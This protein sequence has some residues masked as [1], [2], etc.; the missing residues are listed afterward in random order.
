M[1]KP[2]PVTNPVA[3]LSG[4]VSGTPEPIGDRSTLNVPAQLKSHE[5]GARRVGADEVQVRAMLRLSR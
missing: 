2:A 3:R 5:L 1:M 4:A